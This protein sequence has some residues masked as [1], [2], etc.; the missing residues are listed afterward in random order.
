MDLVQH[1]TGLKIA[2]VFADLKT[3][4][5]VRKRPKGEVETF[6]GKVREIRATEDVPVSTEDCGSVLL[7]F[8]NG[9]RGCLWVSQTTAGRKNCL[10]CEIAGSGE[11]LCWDSETPNEL[12][13]GRRDRANERLLKDPGLV[14]EAA[15]AVIGYPGGHNEGYP[16]TFKQSFRAFYE[17]IAGNDPGAEPGFATFAEGHHEV[18]LCE[19]ILKSH[20]EG[21][22]VNVKS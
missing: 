7:R 13:I 19:A 17:F 15:R 1:I 3:V 21:C 9:A 16:D 6:S 4:H 12:W 14:S 18:V 11:A 22:W 10:R 20:R 8:D 2:E 5:P